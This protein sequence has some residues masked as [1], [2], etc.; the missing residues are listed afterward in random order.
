MGDGAV[1]EQGTHSELLRHPNGPYSS[2]VSG[3]KLRDQHEVEMGD[4]HRDTI[5]THGEDMTKEAKY[6][7]HVQRRDLA[8]SLA[9][10]II[11]QKVKLN[12]GQKHNY[13]LPYLFMRMGE[14]NRAA[15]KNY[16][17]G[18]VAACGT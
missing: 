5:S 15:W 7:V 10:D 13:S 3:Q 12:D 17:I 4:S 2:L 18:F 6:D 9:S 8:P 1:L 16:A 14:I 11:Y